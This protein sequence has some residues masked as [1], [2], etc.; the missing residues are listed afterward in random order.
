[1]KQN[2]I[3]NHAADQLAAYA[4]LIQD[5][6]AGESGSDWDCPGALADFNDITRTAMALRGLSEILSPSKGDMHAS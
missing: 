3:L 4:K 2:D 6:F 5:A 1:M